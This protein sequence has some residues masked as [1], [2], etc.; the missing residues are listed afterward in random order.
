MVP[1]LLWTTAAPDGRADPIG[2]ACSSLARDMVP[3]FHPWQTQCR[4][5]Q[6]VIK[7]K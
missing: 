2:R 6:Y 5:N 1:L 3:T 7:I 4:A